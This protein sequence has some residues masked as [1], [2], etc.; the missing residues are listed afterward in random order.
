MYVELGD[1]LVVAETDERERA[2]TVLEV[3]ESQDPPN[4]L[5]R[6]Y[7]TGTQEVLTPPAKALFLNLGPMTL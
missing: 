2:C 7:D 3:K 4:Y 1:R 6:W 5:V